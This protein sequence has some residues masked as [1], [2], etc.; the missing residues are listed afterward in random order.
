[1]DTLSQSEIEALSAAIRRGLEPALAKGGSFYEMDLLGQKGGFTMEDIAVG[2]REGK[3]CPQCGTA[4]VK[5]KT[6][7]TSSF[8]CPTCQKL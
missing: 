2:Y 4:I 7:S 6:G 1:M 5:I 8:I 3:P